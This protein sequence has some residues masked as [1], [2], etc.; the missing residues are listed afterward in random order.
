M[1]ERKL[2]ANIWQCPDNTILQSK[3]RHDCVF[4]TDTTT[5]E[6]CMVDGGIEYY[7]R[8]SGSLKDLCVYSDDPHEKQ[9][10]LFKWGSKNGWVTPAEMTKEHI[11][12]ILETQTH[13]PEHIRILFENELG[14]RKENRDE[15]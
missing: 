6:T 2:I 5:G 3:Y 15:W 7:I 13:I 14:Y 1:S 10:E 9:R 11:E 12:A 8:L 4:H